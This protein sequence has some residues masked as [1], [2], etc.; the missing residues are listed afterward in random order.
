MKIIKGFK[1]GVDYAVAKNMIAN[2]WY[3]DLKGKNL[4]NIQGTK[5][6]TILAQM[7]FWF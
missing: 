3:Y 7:S 4:G 2:L 6:K 5:E 1:I